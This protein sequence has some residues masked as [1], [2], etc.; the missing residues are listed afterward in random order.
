MSKAAPPPPF[1]ATT[2]LAMSSRAEPPMPL[3]GSG[4]PK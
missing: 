3:P 1:P 2:L 4:R